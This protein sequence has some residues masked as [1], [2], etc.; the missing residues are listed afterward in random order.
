MLAHLMIVVSE[1]NK[2]FA[3]IECF[4]TILAILCTR[5]MLKS[6]VVDWGEW[7]S[8]HGSMGCH[9]ASTPSKTR[10]DV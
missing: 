8:C 3:L 1:Q 2:Q 4:H 10:L 9:C 6:W 7:H 5:E